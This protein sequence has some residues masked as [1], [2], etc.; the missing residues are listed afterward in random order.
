MI[1]HCSLKINNTK[2]HHY[3]GHIFWL[4]LLNIF[5]IIR[6]DDLELAGFIPERIEANIFVVSVEDSIPA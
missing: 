2:D 3:Q 6:M 5:P 4:Q 1:V